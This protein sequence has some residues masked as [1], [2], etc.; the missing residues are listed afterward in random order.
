MCLLKCMEHILNLQK[1]IT[2]VWM[3]TFRNWEA[4][5]G[6]VSA[7]APISRRKTRRIFH[8][9][10]DVGLEVPFHISTL[11]TLPFGLL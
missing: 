5:K 7:G 10:L 8:S 3:L 1:Q 9:A 6:N 4:G 11:P 2:I